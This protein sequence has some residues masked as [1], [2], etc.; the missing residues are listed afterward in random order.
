MIE[1]VVLGIEEQIA[2]L[3][4]RDAAP[5][6]PLL[7]TLFI[8][9]VLANLCGLVPGVRAPTASIETP[10]ALAAI[11]FLSVHFYGVRIRGSHPVSERLSQT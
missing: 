8:F 4:N 10:A 5:F 11:V 2:A 9:L 1:T 6:L 7:G 3:L